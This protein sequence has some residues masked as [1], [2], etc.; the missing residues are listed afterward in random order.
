MITNENNMTQPS[1]P[2]EM[3]GFHAEGHI[4]IF[5]PDSNEVFT[6]KRNAIHYENMSLALATSLASG[7][8]AIAGMAFGRGGTV[9]DPTGI[10]TYLTPNT[11]GTSSGLYDQTFFKGSFENVSVNHLAGTTFSDVVFTVLLDFNEPSDQPP[12]DNQPGSSDYVFDELGLKGPDD[13]TPG[14]GLLLTHVVF[15]PVQKAQNRRI[16]IDYTIRIQSLTTSLS[17]I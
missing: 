1:K 4:K 14:D 12:I 7:G 13:T 17:E 5:D 3:L 10:I 9:V 6:D 2:N 8:S 15:H 16:Q 11:V